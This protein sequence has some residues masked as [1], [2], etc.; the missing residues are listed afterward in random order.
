MNKKNQ[1]A[2]APPVAL[3]GVGDWGVRTLDRLPTVFEETVKK[4]ALNSDLQSLVLSSSPVK[5]TA[6]EKSLSGSGTGGDRA[7]GEKA[8]AECR[9]AVRKELSGSGIVIVAAGLGGGIGSGAAPP[10]CRLAAEL[11]LP[12]LAL[13]TRPFEFEGKKRAANS[14]EAVE[15]LTAAGVSYL[16]FSLDRML[17]RIEESAPCDRAFE[18]C[19]RLLDASLA[20]VISYL[21]VSPPLGGDQARLRNVFA[22]E[23]ES[24][25]VTVQCD[26][27]DKILASVKSAVTQLGLNPAE[28][29]SARGAL[30]CVRAARLP[31]IAQLRPALDVLSKILGEQSE[32]LFTVRQSSEPED[33]IRVDL[34]I[35][36]AEAR[37]GRAPSAPLVFETGSLPPRQGKL[38]IGQ[39]YRGAFSDTEP[40]LV[41]GEDLDIP[42]FIREGLNTG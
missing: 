19:D 3:W 1:R 4:V 26:H 21:T 16:S 27:P 37:A 32:L 31:T 10:L 29:K 30:L 25:A 2:P 7:R 42:T 28:L 24:V 5:I 6:G 40:T 12:V 38:P 34:V 35:G 22:P 13:L 18:Y 11:G 14:R 36:G 17:G 23:G 39:E 15:A 41:D 33:R 9:A 20:A 8:F